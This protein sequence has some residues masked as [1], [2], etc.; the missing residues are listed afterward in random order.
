MHVT[1]YFR[2]LHNSDASNYF[3][4]QHLEVVQPKLKMNY[5]TVGAANFVDTSNKHKDKVPKDSSKFFWAKLRDL[6]GFASVETLPT[7]MTLEF[8]DGMGHKLYQKVLF[9]RF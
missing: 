1:I 6:G 3:P 4:H 8:I 2:S 5:F 9:P 7:N